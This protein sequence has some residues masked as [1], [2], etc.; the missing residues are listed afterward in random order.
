MPNNKTVAQAESVPVVGVEMWGLTHLGVTVIPSGVTLGSAFYFLSKDRILENL[1]ML[2]RIRY[3]CG[4][5]RFPKAQCFL[6]E[7][8]KPNISV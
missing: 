8:Q 5:V 2:L 3:K 6:P 1:L 4:T 7:L